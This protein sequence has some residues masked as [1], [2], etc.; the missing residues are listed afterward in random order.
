[1]SHLRLRLCHRWR[2]ATRVREHRRRSNA[3]STELVISESTSTA[4]TR[5]IVHTR[6]HRDLQPGT[7]TRRPGR[8][9][10]FSTRAPTARNARRQ[11]RTA[12]G[13]HRNDRSL[14]VPPRPRGLGRG[15]RSACHRL[16]SSTRRRSP[17]LLRRARSRS[18]TGRRRSAA[19][20][21]QLH[22]RSG[23]L[24]THRRP[25][26]L[27][28]TRPFEARRHAD[29][30]CHD[31]AVQAGSGCTETDDNA[32][33]FA[34][35]RRRSSQLGDRGIRLRRADADEP[36][37]CRRGN[38]GFGPGGRQHAPHGRG[39]TGHEPGEHRNQRHR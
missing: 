7:D 34:G 3:A 26:R 20:R 9:V 30:R 39:H 1:M 23:T 16:A 12:H 6:L 36:D 11:R 14:A 37:G 10:T 32:A 17:W 31:S 4:A 27:R 35:S 21:R 18:S 22:V 15:R 19:T 28:Q 2:G 5:C 38:P 33:D 29:P 25:R 24:G 13:A 8:H